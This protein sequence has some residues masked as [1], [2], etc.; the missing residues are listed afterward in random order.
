MLQT[1]VPAT[2]CHVPGDL[3]PHLHFINLLNSGSSHWQLSSLETF[4]TLLLISTRKTNL[5]CALWIVLQS[6]CISAVREHQVT[7]TSINFVMYANMFIV[8]ADVFLLLLV[9]PPFLQVAGKQAAYHGL[10]EYYQS[11]VC[12]ADK[13]IG[14]EISRLEVSNNFSGFHGHCCSSD[15]VLG[16]CT[17]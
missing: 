14:E 1:T 12:K 6:W 3:N 5:R 13:S 17:V 11:L 8:L 16:F 9:V 2:R 10:T 15:R 4:C 7:Q